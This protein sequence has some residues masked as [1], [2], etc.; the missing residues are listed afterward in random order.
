MPLMTQDFVAKSG[1]CEFYTVRNKYDINPNNFGS[2]AVAEL[3]EDIVTFTEEFK[4][5][6]AT[7]VNL[8]ELGDVLK[9]SW[10]P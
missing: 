7:S 3:V 9:V 6:K 10:I 8:D 2:D 1:I 4:K 5:R